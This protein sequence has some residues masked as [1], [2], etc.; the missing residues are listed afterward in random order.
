MK[1]WLR[2]EIWITAI[3]ACA[4]TMSIAA[5]VF[6]SNPIQ[7]IVNGKEISPDVPPQMID[8]R[9]MV[10]IRWVSE[11][12]GAEVQ[13][14]QENQRVII[15]SSIEENESA[16]EQAIIALVEQFGRKLKMVSLTSSPSDLAKSMQEHYRDFAAPELIAYWAEN[17]EEAPGRLT[18]SPW[19]ERIDVES[20]EKT[21]K[22]VYKVT[23]RIVE[24]V[25]GG[26]E[27]A[28]RPIE[29]EL[30]KADGRWLI[31]GSVLGS[32]ETIMHSDQD[33][34][35]GYITLEDDTLYLDRVEVIT[36]EEGDRITGLGF[37][38][39]ERMAELG[40]QDEDLP[41]GYY[42][43]ELNEESLAYELSDE[44]VYTF[45]DVH[46]L[47]VENEES[48]RRYFTTDKEEFMEHLSTIPGK[49]KYPFLV[50]VSGGKVLSITEVF[51]FT[52]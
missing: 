48:D 43:H 16:D 30:K 35:A 40:L 50:E 4:V 17:A 28:I 23:G 22:D 20:I 1:K 46:L 10:P 27:A 33:V 29:L 31:H 39:P 19:P 18:S 34:L 49:V 9:V 21:A 52:Q 32:Y 7:I 45:T 41:N 26:I 24:V 2:K 3:V 13:W 6:A 51:L 47:F 36:T 11:A 12:L 8:N 15:R 38:N 37:Y 25:G 42:I 14:D 5:S 44:T